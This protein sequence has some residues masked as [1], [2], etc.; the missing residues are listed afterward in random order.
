[1]KLLIA[2][3]IHG[4][5]A[6]ARAV[7]CAKEREGCERVLLLGDLLYHGPRN[8][9][10]AAY[11]PKEVIALLNSHKNEILA[12]RGNCEAE[13]DQMVLD[14]PVLADYAFLSLDGVRVFATHGHLFHLEHL[15]PLLPGDILL[16]GHTHIP[17]CTSF[18]DRN[19]YLN[20]GSAALPKGGFPK[21]YMVFD[22]GVFTTKDFEGSLLFT[23]D[24]R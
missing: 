18:G 7:F 24:A 9:L 23:H 16:H 15:P 8:D 22:S 1:M 21:S 14:F 17:A 5:I 19:V 11:A 13:V 10:P 6:A 4:D 3:D 12:V 20:P 2:S